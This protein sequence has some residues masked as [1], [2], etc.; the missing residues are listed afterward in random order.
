MTEPKHATLHRD[1]IYIIVTV[2]VNIYCHVMID[3]L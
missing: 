2:P 1:I 3:T